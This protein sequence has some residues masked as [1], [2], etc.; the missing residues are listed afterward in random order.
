MA[1]GKP[2]QSQIDDVLNDAY[3]SVDSG[4]SRWPGMTYE[5]G[6]ASALDW[7]SGNVTDNPFEEN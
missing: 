1:A 4:S 5:Q 7:V 2:T 6:V 3:E